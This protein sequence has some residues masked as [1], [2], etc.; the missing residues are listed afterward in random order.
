MTIVFNEVSVLYRQLLRD[1]GF[2][3]QRALLCDILFLQGFQRPRQVAVVTKKDVW[4]RSF[5]QVS[6]KLQRSSAVERKQNYC[7]FFFFRL[8]PTATA[9]SNETIKND[10]LDRKGRPLY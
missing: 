10:F 3:L 7:F 2:L 4:A 9:S 1:I 6:G 5:A 8:Q